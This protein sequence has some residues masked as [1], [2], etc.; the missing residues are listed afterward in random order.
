MHSTLMLLLLMKIKKMNLE[1]WPQNSFNKKLYTKWKCNFP[2][3]FC[4]IIMA[5][6]VYMQTIIILM[7][8]WVVDGRYPP[9]IYENGL[10]CTFMLCALLLN[11]D[12]R[13]QSHLHFNDGWLETI[14]P[15]QLTRIPHN[16][17]ANFLIRTLA[18]SPTPS[19]VNFLKTPG[20]FPFISIRG[21]G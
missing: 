8:H 14:T 11:S 9:T 18:I 19:A 16:G 15:P 5:F 20:D 6:T 4:A 7:A 17:Q 12:H 2:L 10:E 21:G 1:E 3:S 13:H